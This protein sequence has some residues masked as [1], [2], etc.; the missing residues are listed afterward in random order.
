V[1]SEY[2]NINNNS[3]AS[4]CLRV[5][6]QD[7]LGSSKEMRQEGR[8]HFTIKGDRATGGRACAGACGPGSSAVAGE[9][10]TA[11]MDNIDGLALSLSDL[12]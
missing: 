4:L 6:L 7:R 8:L 11:M 5:F 3:E 12:A 10:I 1:K 9:F 2:K